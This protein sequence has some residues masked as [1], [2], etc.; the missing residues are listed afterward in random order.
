MI[1]Y[2]TNINDIGGIIVKQDHRYIV[3]DNTT[4]QNL[5]VS[6]TELYPEKETSGH[7]HDGQEEVYYFIE[8]KGSMILGQKSFSVNAGDIVLIP[9]GAFHKVINTASR[10]NKNS[11]ALRFVCVFDGARD[12][13]KTFLD[14]LKGFFK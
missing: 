12:Q 7:S 5:V 8:G 11:K 1:E 2:R 13:N 3:K 9:D 14:R 10:K 6:S 4:L